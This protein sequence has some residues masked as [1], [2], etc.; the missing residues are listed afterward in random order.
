MMSFVAMS[1]AGCALLFSL[2][3]M[4]FAFL[5]WATLVGFKNSSHKIQYVPVQ[6]PTFDKFSTK[7]LERKLDDE[8]GEPIPV[9]GGDSSTGL[10]LVDSFKKHIYTDEED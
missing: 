7:D 2:V 10:G 8:T 1:V 9:N 5:S 6:D 3:A 4:I